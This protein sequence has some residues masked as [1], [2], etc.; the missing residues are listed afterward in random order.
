[1]DPDYAQDPSSVVEAEKTTAVPRAVERYRQI[2]GADR[3]GRTKCELFLRHYLH[4]SDGTTKEVE[5]VHVHKPVA[6][7]FSSGGY[8]NVFLDF[9]R[10]TDED[11]RIVWDILDRYMQSS[12]G[13]S[14][15]PEEI[16]QGYYRND[17]GE[18]ALVYFPIM[19]LVL[20]PLGHELEYMIHG[21]RPLLYTLAATAPDKDLTVL[22]LVF[23]D[24]LFVVDEQILQPDPIRVQEEALNEARIEMSGEI[25]DSDME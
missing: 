20:S 11:L 8:V 12:N 7:I 17:E 3:S 5:E 13:V 25:P 16:E 14:F 9:G 10:R 15:L 19:E 21:Y 1:V 22:H 18:Q 2:S 23:K 24:N 6:H 4:Y